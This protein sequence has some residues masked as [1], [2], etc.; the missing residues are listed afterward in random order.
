MGGQ[1]W[2]ESEPGVGQHLHLHRLAGPRVGGRPR[3]SPSSWR[4]CSVLVVDDNPAAR[5]ILVDALKGVAA[6]VDAVSSGAGGR[7]RREAARRAGTPTTSSSWTGRC[8]AW[9]ACRPRARSSRTGRCRKQPA[10]VMVTAFGR[11]EVREEAEKLEHRRLPGEAGHQVHARGR[12][13]DALRPRRSRRRRRPPVQRGREEIRLDGAADP[14]GRGQR[15]QPADR[16]R[17]AGG[18][19]RHASTWPTTGARRWRRWQRRRTRPP[20]TSS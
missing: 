12:P 11:E 18:R 19:R 2:L 17:A 20:T 9:T 10:V 16:R 14:A 5:D 6:Q 1:I 8:R 7:R 3:S 13:G 15:D 4:A